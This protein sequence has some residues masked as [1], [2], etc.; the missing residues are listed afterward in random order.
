MCPCMS[1]YSFQK[2]TVFFIIVRGKDMIETINT[3]ITIVIALIE[4]LGYIISYLSS[5]RY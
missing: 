3:L 4:N 5:L 2:I 1:W